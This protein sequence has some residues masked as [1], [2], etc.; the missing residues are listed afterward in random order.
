M[1][2]LVVED[3]PLLRASIEDA[4][5]DAGHEV[6]SA[7]DGAEA[8]GLLDSEMALPEV[9]IL[10]LMMPN[11]N[12]ELFR[13]HQLSDPRIAEIP[14]LVIT[15][16]ALTHGTQQALGELPILR[17]PFALT[18]LLELIERLAPPALHAP[19]QCACGC[20]YDDEAWHTL[21]LIGE[22]DNGRGLGERFEL[23]QCSLCHSTLAWEL[24]RHSISVPCLD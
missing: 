5:A 13:I 10:D 21:P 18:V 24:G 14:T 9:I 4:L 17:K 19:K 16:K 6:T 3:D 23:R 22:I 8:L 2:V 15:A 1:R 20:A 7:I 11:M 12:G